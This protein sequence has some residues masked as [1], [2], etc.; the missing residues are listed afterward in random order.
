MKRQNFIATVLSCALFLTPYQS[1][2]DIWG[3]DVGVLLQIL[4]QTLEEV[5]KLQQI[6]NNGRD[7][8]SL[9][10]DVN[11]GRIYLPICAGLNIRYAHEKPSDLPILLPTRFDLVININ[12]TK[13]LSLTV[14]DNLLVA[15]PP[16]LVDPARRSK[17]CQPFDQMLQL[18]IPDQ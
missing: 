6:L 13:A 15:N 4:A 8:L 16:Y 9:L 5:I 1:R 11:S 7:T 3:A 17:E 18:A 2:A 12:T 10:Q 14:P